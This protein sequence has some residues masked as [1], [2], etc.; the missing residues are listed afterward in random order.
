M[1]KGEEGRGEGGRS[2]GQGVV[3]GGE[4]RE[5]E[6]LKNLSSK[7]QDTHTHKHIFFGTCFSL[8]TQL[9]PCHCNGGPAGPT[10]ARG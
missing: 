5:A 4:E 9:F 6:N 3:A 2:G 8:E 1:K 10:S 7:R